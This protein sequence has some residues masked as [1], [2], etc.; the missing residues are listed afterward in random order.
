MTRPLTPAEV[1]NLVGGKVLQGDDG[2][3][4]GV[5]TLAKA[6]PHQASFLSNMKYKADLQSTRAG[7]VLLKEGATIPDEARFAVVAVP[8]AYVAFTRLQRYFHPAPVSNRCIHPSAVIH[9]DAKLADDVQAEVVDP[10]GHVLQ[11]AVVDDVLRRTGAV[12]EDHVDVGV[13]VEEPARHGHH[14]G[15]ADPAGEEQHL[16]GREVD[17]V[18]Q[19]DRTVHR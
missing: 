8:D 13:G 1:A 17:G 6:Q 14:R 5:Q 18:E 4:S 2:L 19:A 3:I 10:R 15:D 12:D 7:L 9:A 11:L 16:V